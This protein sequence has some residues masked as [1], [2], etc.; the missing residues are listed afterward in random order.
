[1]KSGTP[2]RG[3]TDVT[4]GPKRI[5]S[6]PRVESNSGLGGSLGGGDDSAADGSC[7]VVVTVGVRGVLLAVARAVRPRPDDRVTLE[8]DDL[9]LVISQCFSLSPVL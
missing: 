5:A 8:D 4:S 9:V 3:A 6:S 2:D 7:D 1:M